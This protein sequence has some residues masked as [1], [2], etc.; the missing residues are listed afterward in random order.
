MKKVL[1][2]LMIVVLGVGGC[3]KVDL[4]GFSSLA[5]TMQSVQPRP[6]PSSSEATTA[7]MLAHHLS[8]KTPP[9]EIP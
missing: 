6:A 4:S 1:F 9:G 3:G 5:W 7:P 2:L 8:P